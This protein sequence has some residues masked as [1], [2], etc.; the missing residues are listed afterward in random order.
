MNVR[1]KL[2]IALIVAIAVSL[3]FLFRDELKP[4]PTLKDFSGAT[5]LHPVVEE[6]KNKLVQQANDQGISIVITEG[7]RS[8]EEQDKLYAKG[9]TEE[10]NIVTYSKGGQSYHNYGL[11]I[12]FAI[13]LKDGRVVWDMEYDG[14]HN[15]QS[16][17]MEVVDIAKGLEFEWGGDWQD[18]K[19]YPH[20]QMSPKI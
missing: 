7:F 4:V 11:A 17:W 16:D 13:R 6:K 5:E 2:A 1:K 10:G 20:L 19:D 18:F 14:N 15:N 9:R 12:D 8:K 3:L